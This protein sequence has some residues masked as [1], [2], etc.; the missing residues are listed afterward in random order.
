MEVVA[1]V[2]VSDN[3]DPNPI[4]TLVS[5][6]SNE[7][8]NGVGD[9]NTVDDIVIVDDFYFKLRAERSG[10]G[11]GRIY[12][13]TYMVTDTCG[14]STTQS[15]IVTVPH[16]KGKKTVTIPHKKAKK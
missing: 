16:S 1:T 11:T 5:I 14:N 15:V 3:L 8:D 13:I 10:I 9:G 7:P 2:V 4:I 6:T 12:T